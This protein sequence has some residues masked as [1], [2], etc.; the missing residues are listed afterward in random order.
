MQP[1]QTTPGLK[2]AVCEPPMRSACCPLLL[3]RLWRLVDPGSNL[4]L[5]TIG[6][7]YGNDAVATQPQSLPGSDASL[8]AI[9]RLRWPCYYL[10]NTTPEEAAPTHVPCRQATPRDKGRATS[11]PIHAAQQ[12]RSAASLLTRNQWRFDTPA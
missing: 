3:C 8:R 9:F 4:T 12:G 10:V 2:A 1:I 11:E 5:C 6:F 7:F